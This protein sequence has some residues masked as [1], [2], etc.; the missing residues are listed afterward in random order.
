MRS[1]RPLSFA[2]SNGKGTGACVPENAGGGAPAETAPL[3]AATAALSPV[4]PSPMA[5]RP[6]ATAPRI[7]RRFIVF[8]TSPPN[9]LNRG[10]DLTE[11]CLQYPI[12]PLYPRD[13]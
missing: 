9:G 13:A 3:G 10:V 2:G 8:M 4:A 11:L 6:T 12:P 5:G 1:E 7:S